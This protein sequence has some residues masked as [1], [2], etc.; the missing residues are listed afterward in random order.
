MSGN[1]SDRKRLIAITK[2]N[3]RNNHIY[4]SGH[5][6]FFPRECYGASS[7]RKGAGRLLK[8]DI[9]GLLEP[10]ETDIATN[11]GNGGPRNF[12]RKR[13]WVGRFFKKHDICEGDIVA[14]ERRGRYEYRI[15]PFE[16]KNFREGSA[17]PE[18]WPGLHRTKPAV[19][20]LFAGCGGLA[21][22]LHQAGFE[23]ALAV[24]WDASCCDT[25]RANIS[26]RILQCAIQ[27]MACF[28]A[29]DVIAGCPPCQ[30]LGNL[31]E[32]V[33]NDPRTELWRHFMRPVETVRP[34]A[35]LMENV[36]PL[37]GSQEFVEVTKLAESLAYRIVGRVLNAADYGVPQTRKRAIVIVLLGQTASQNRR[38]RDYRGSY[39]NAA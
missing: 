2:G 24:E 32:R 1:A 18:H 30:G 7:K 13:G 39:A 36:P 31:G 8:I 22:G 17:V 25:F 38:G 15:Y 20:D 6:D 11:G 33:P 37:L 27:E 28:P 10:V 16:S 29:A 5:H 35:F 3:F 34:Q 21:Y 4:L 19:I 12:F 14:I 26:P 23:V 9:E